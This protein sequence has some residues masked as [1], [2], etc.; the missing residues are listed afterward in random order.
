MKTNM[1]QRDVRFFHEDGCL[2]RTVIGSD[3]RNYTHRCLKATFETVACGA[4][5]EAAL[6]PLAEDARRYRTLRRD[7]CAPWF[8]AVGG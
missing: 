1:R 6:R 2:V 5:N 8:C 4:L 3:G 7:D